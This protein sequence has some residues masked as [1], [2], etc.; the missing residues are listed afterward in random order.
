M[1]CGSAR[2]RHWR[3][4]G[5]STLALPKE[6]VVKRVFEVNPDSQRLTPFLGG[7]QMER[8]PVL[9]LAEEA[10]PVQTG[11]LEADP[12]CLLEHRRG[13]RAVALGQKVDHRLTVGSLLIHVPRQMENHPKG[14][15]AVI[16]AAGAED[17]VGN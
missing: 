1:E 11:H 14:L 10:A 5:M 15:V 6:R 17:R 2:P 12:G 4:F 16:P 9:V 7:N 3:L 8:L 13:G